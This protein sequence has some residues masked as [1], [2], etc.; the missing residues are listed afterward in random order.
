MKKGRPT[1]YSEEILD[2]AREYLLNLPQDEV[3]HSI[4]GLSDYLCI[5]RSTIYDWASQ[6]EKKDFSDILGKILVKQGKSLV[7]GGLN[8]KLN[9]TITKLILTKHDYRDEVKKEIEG[10]LTIGKVLDELEDE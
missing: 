10:K 5:A 2:K 8:G 4:E 6:E 3:I 9:S 7:N 1:D